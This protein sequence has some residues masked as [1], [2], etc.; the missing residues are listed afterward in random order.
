[1]E[2]SPNEGE[3]FVTIEKN[4]IFDGELN[5]N[6]ANPEGKFL[7]ALT[8]KLFAFTIFCVISRLSFCRFFSWLRSLYSIG[9]YVLTFFVVIVVGKNKEQYACT[10]VLRKRNVE[11]AP[12]ITNLTVSCYDGPFL[13]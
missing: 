11:Q 8:R 5:T 12:L 4:D 9:F 2:K 7:Y 3:A 13:L 10:C 1:M 6:L